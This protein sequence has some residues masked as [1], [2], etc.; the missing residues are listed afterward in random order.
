MCRAVRGCCLFVWDTQLINCP[1]STIELV[2]T[3]SQVKRSRRKAMPTLGGRGGGG[4]GRTLSSCFSSVVFVFSDQY[5]LATLS[6]PQS[7]FRSRK[8]HKSL[9]VGRLFIGGGG[10]GGMAM[11]MPMAPGAAAF[12]GAP[13][14]RLCLFRTLI[15]VCLFVFLFPHSPRYSITNRV[16]SQRDGRTTHAASGGGAP[17]PAPTPVATTTTTTVEAAPVR[18]AALFFYCC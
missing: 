12:G 14:T 11:A 8:H 3:I 4:G 13:R 15:D 5:S 10:G 6:M 7:A 17:P 16:L 18:T 1:R 2:L 9:S